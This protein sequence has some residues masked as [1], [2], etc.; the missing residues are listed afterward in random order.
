MLSLASQG[1]MTEDWDLTLSSLRDTID[2]FEAHGRP[3]MAISAHAYLSMALTAKG[4]LQHALDQ[5]EAALA[6]ADGIESLPRTEYALPYLARARAHEAAGRKA[7]ALADIA[8]AEK[9]AAGWAAS[10]AAVTRI[11]KLAAELR[12]QAPTSG[13]TPTR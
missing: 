5:A 2:V 9:A 12:A 7:K 4:Q 6:L 10:N 3:T 8:E 13:A 1:W 11:A